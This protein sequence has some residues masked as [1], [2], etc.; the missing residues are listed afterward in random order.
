LN[1][2]VSQ[3]GCDFPVR[4]CPLAVAKIVLG[5]AAQPVCHVIKGISFN[6][7]IKEENGLPDP[8]RVELG[9]ALRYQIFLRQRSLPVVDDDKGILG[10]VD[11]ATPC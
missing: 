7:L 3:P 11:D 10:P 8:A 9:P 1:N 2:I 6:C 4:N 5:I